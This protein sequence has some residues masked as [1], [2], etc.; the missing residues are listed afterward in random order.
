MSGVSVSEPFAIL[1]GRTPIDAFK[2]ALVIDREHSYGATAL[3]H[4]L[5]DHGLMVDIVTEHP[6]IGADLSPGALM[7][8]LSRLLKD[9]VVIHPLSQ[10]DGVIEGEARIKNLLTGQARG[11][12]G[13]DLVVI[14]GERVA[15][16]APYGELAEAGHDVALVGDAMAPRQIWQAVR[17]G[18]LAGYHVATPTPVTHR[19]AAHA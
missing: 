6:M 17:E 18:F 14:V 13:L 12:A 15:N 7:G 1:T 8:V 5:R 16:D 10:V 2:H 3:C 4:H 9:G 19:E 11:L